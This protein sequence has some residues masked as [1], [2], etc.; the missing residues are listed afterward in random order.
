MRQKNNKTALLWDLALAKKVWRGILVLSVFGIGYSVL[1]ASFALASKNVIDTAVAMASG[2]TAGNLIEASLVLV[3]LILLQLGMQIVVSELTV[4]VNGKLNI[5]C[6]RR[7]FSALIHKEAACVFRY[8]SGELLNRLTGDISVVT[9]AISSL[10][11]DLIHY[12]TRAAVSFGVLF[13][14]DKWFSL[15]CLAALPIVLIA[16]RLYRKKMKNLHKRVQE[17]DG[18]TRSFMQESLANLLVIKSFGSETRVTERATALQT[19]NFHLSLKR[20]HISILSNIVFFIA[21]TAGYYFALAWGA[22]RLSRGL[23]SFGSLTAI[24]QLVEQLQSPFRSLSSLLP[25]YYAMTAS[26]ERLLELENLPEE[27]LQQNDFDRSEAYRNA[28]WFCAEH[29]TFS[30]EGK[31]VLDDVSFRLRKGD[32]AAV[33]G[34]SGAGKSTLLKLFLGIMEPEQGEIFLLGK[35]GEKLLLGAETRALFAYV[36]QGN[37]ILS[38]TIRENIAFAKESA[39]EEEIISAAKHAEIW[40]EIQKLPQGLD[41]V[42]GEGGTGLSEGQVQRLAIARA[43]LY[44]APVLLLD[45]CTSALDEKTEKAVL[46]NLIAMQSKTCLTVSHKAAAKECCNV[47]FYV[48]NGKIYQLEKYDKTTV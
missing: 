6:K 22:F 21:M 9:N 27:N 42:L 5:E 24:L 36:P 29:V 39:S 34:L 48:E 7:L 18:K 19:E 17:S 35:S 8:H 45:E 16:A 47:N 1:G 14:L 32:F 15:I 23:M 2:E 10:I 44:D 11:P 28:E 38:G 3:G 37:L 30:Y 12:V 20:A 46:E 31:K 41:T 40:E 43:L 4:R 26:T 33:T 25:Q 13:V